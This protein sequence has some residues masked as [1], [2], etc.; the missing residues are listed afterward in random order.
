[1][2]LLSDSLCL[3]DELE[4]STEGGIG[5]HRCG[6][7]RLATTPE[8]MDEFARVDGL[9]TIVGVPYELVSPDEASELFPLASMAGIR[10]AAHLPDDGYVDPAR[11]TMELAG[12]AHAAGAVLCRRARVTGLDHDH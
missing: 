6:S 12:R 5:L 3:Y 11:L 7:V 10:G 8:H 4:R 1:M 2:Y 9:A